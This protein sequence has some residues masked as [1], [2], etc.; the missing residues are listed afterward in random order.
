ML[1]RTNHDRD[2]PIRRHA[3]PPLEAGSRLC[4]FPFYCHG[5]RRT[6]PERFQHLR[7]TRSCC[8]RTRP[9]AH[10][11]HA[12]P[13]HSDRSV[14]HPDYEYYRER[15]HVFTDVAAAPNSIGLLDDFNFEGRDVKIM[16]R[17]VSANYFAVMAIRPFLGPLF[18]RG[19]DEA[20]TQVAVMTWACWKRLGSDPK[21]VGKV[22]ANHTIIGVTPKEF[23]GSFYGLNGDLF[24]TLREV[25]GD[26][27]W[28][29]KR[30]V[31][32][33]FLAGRLKPGISQ[34]QAQAEMTTLSSQLSSAYPEDDKSR[35]AVIT[36]S[37]SCRRTNSLRLNG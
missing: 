20:K 27:S 33:L 30:G 15:N 9:P 22:L 28:L 4:F 12:L 14:S 13:Q 6:G 16:T 1:S 11:V 2:P 31:R 10:A 26:R 34:Q 19:D 5:P 32:R 23:T 17:P 18:S 36:R 8:P 35:T 24:T 25:D 21:I 3:A 37:S 29:T 7:F